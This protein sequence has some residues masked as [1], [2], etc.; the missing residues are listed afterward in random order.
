MVRV[1]LTAAAQKALPRPEHR[2][3]AKAPKKRQP[4]ACETRRGNEH[5]ARLAHRSRAKSFCPA[6][7]TEAGRRPR[8]NDSRGRARRGEETNTVRVLLTAAARKAFA[9]PGTQKPG[10]G[11]EKTTAA[12]VRDA[13]R[14]RTRCA[15]CSPQVWYFC[16]SADGN[17]KL[18]RSGDW[19]D[20]QKEKEGRAAF[21]PVWTWRGGAPPP[22]GPPAGTAHGRAKSGCR[23][24]CAPHGGPPCEHRHFAGRPRAARGNRCSRFPH[25]A[26]AQDTAEEGCF[27]PARRAPAAAHRP[28][29]AAGALPQI[30]RLRDEKAILPGGRAAPP[31]GAARP[32][33]RFL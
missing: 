21:R 1:L 22:A 19:V 30:L 24:V 28:R 5:G 17:E 3:R 23:S 25:R 7:N 4:R 29:C 16:A 13:E 15:S 8:K 10:E 27:S 9:L 6:R 14:K 18:G 31:A 20:Q 33:R 2:S 11:P 32:A 26:F 12:G